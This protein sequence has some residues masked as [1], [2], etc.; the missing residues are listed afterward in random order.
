[1]DFYSDKGGEWTNFYHRQQKETT[2]LKFEDNSSQ[3]ALKVP[4]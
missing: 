2:K 4:A 3:T 1:M